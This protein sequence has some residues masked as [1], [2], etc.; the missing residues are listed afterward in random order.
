MLRALHAVAPGS[1]ADVLTGGGPGVIHAGPGPYNVVVDPV[2][3]AV[4]AVIDWELAR[5]GDPI[6]DLALV[7]WNMRIW[8][9]SSGD[10]LRHLYDAYG[11][12]PKWSRRHVAMIERCRS[13]YA[14]S[15]TRRSGSSYAARRH[16]RS[17]ADELDQT[18]KVHK[19]HYSSIYS[20]CFRRLVPSSSLNPS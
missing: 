19:L 12:L 6:E 15:R 9:R 18:A 7:E 14:T 2:T 16:S 8:Y 4:R 1:F 3:G 11:A 20:S 13:Y 17:S 10:V 5:L